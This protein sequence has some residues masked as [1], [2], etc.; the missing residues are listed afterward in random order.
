MISTRSITDTNI[1]NFVNQL[2]DLSWNNITTCND[3]EACFN[4]FREDF[5]TLFEL[6]FPIQTKKLNKNIHK[7]T[8]YMTA[9]LLVSRAN[10]N[11]LHKIAIHKPNNENCSAYKRYRNLYNTLLRNSKKLY[12]EENLKANVKNPKKTWDLLKEAT[13][14]KYK[15]NNINGIQINDL[16]NENEK[17]MAEEFNT[18]F[19]EVG[20]KI[21]NSIKN[22]SLEP[23]DFIPPNP[24]PPNLE[25]G[26]ISPMVVKNTISNFKS[27]TSQDIDGISNK[28]LKA[29]SNEICTPLAHIFNLSPNQGIFPSKLKA[30]QTVP[31]FKSGNSELCDNYRPISLLSSLSKVL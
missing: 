2:A 8:N 9:R 20:V 16:L 22:T 10:K 14:Q 28:L 24:N 17:D 6:N 7:I 26:R 25:F 18:F 12:F 5:H 21:S 31:I 4:I 23:D 30:S 3:T 13:N 1:A 11:K 29:I 15:T 19:S 27:K